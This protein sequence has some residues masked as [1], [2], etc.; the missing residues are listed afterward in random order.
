MSNEWSGN[1]LS[2]F[3][4]KRVYWFSRNHMNFFN[5]SFHFWKYGKKNYRIIHQKNSWVWYGMKFD[6]KNIIKIRVTL[7][8]FFRKRFKSC[9]VFFKNFIF[10]HFYIRKKW[11]NEK[12]A[13][14]KGRGKKWPI[15]IICVRIRKKIH[16]WQL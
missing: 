1:L 15:L 5:F 7:H 2:S 8:S 13:G 16:P 14:K 6:C 4:F 12:M 10:I 9:V 11:A 3:H